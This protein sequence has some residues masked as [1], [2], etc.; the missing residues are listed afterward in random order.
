MAVADRRARS[1]PRSASETEVLGVNSPMQLADLERR[2]QRAGRAL[3]EAG[4]RLADPARFDVRGELRCGSDVEIDVNCVFEGRV[5][6]GD[7]V[8][9]GAHCVIR[10][11]RIAPAR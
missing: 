6:L 4:V 7:G 11:A 5:E 8:R 10:N 3:M 2:Y 9:I 1:S